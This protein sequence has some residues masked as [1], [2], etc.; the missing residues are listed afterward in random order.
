MFRKKQDRALRPGISRGEGYLSDRPLVKNPIPPEKKRDF[1]LNA[2]ALG[3]FLLVCL[4]TLAGLAL[5]RGLPSPAEL[6][7][8]AGLP[9]LTILC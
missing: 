9:A 6:G 1:T 5:G 2:A 8:L 7:I 3:L 4:F